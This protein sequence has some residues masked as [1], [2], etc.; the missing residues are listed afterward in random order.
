MRADGVKFRFEEARGHAPAEAELR[1]TVKSLD[2]PVFAYSYEINDNRRGNGD[3]RVQSGE[4][5]TMYLTVKNVGKGR[6]FATMA[7]LRNLSGE[8]LLLHDGRFDLPLE[9]GRYQA[10]CF[11]R[12]TSNPRCRTGK[13]RSSCRSTTTTCAKGW[14]RRSGS[15]RGPTVITPATGAD[16]THPKGTQA[17]TSTTNRMR[18]AGSSRGCQRDRRLLPSDRRLRAVNWRSAGVDSP[19]RTADVTSGGTPSASRSKTRWPPRS[20]FRS[21]SWR[22]GIPTPP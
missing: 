15:D 8:G 12:S 10:R 19:S 3:G 6:S 11:P 21:R 18:R 2:R 7:N 5:L 22:P 16:R 9:P 17:R 4:W 13:P 20:R 14:S 1:A